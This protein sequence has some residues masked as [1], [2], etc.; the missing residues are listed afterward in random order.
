MLQH[1]NALCSG[2]GASTFDVPTPQQL[3]ERVNLKM[4]GKMRWRIQILTLCK[5]DEEAIR[6]QL[7][8]EK[9]SIEAQL[10]KLSETESGKQLVAQIEAE[11]EKLIQARK[12]VERVC[13]FNYLPFSYLIIW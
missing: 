6:R 5:A 8:A 3:V 1:I 11:R 9:K 4:L 7:A 2:T 13:H 12:N 10:N